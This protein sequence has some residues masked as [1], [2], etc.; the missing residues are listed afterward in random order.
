LRV[1]RDCFPVAFI[2][3]I[4]VGLPQGDGALALDAVGLAENIADLPIE[5]QSVFVP[6]LRAVV[7]G[8]KV[9]VA[10]VS[11]AVGLA[12]GIAYLL[13]ERQSF[14]VPGFGAVVVRVS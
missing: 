11:Y 5:R 3:G 6:G 10:E 8:A 9:D 1:E 12:N 2:G 4:A 13:V 14:F 7:A